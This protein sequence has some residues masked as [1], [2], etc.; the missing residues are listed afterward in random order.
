M[1]VV[2]L[3]VCWLRA[4]LSLIATLI[5]ALTAAAKEMVTEDV[6]GTGYCS[7]SHRPDTHSDP[8]LGQL[9]VIYR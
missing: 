7:V 1:A 8:G 3:C 9:S 2:R 5:L 6:L 4:W